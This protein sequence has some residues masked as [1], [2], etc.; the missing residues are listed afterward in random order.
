MPPRL[1]P[2]S[3]GCQVEVAERL[4]VS[5]SNDTSTNHSNARELL[6]TS[7]N[8]IIGSQ[9]TSVYSVRRNST[10]GSALRYDR[11]RIHNGLLAKEAQLI[12]TS[13]LSR[14]ITSQIGPKYS[15]LR[16]STLRVSVPAS[17]GTRKLCYCSEGQTSQT[18][19]KVPAAP[20]V[21]EKVLVSGEHGV[22]ETRLQRKEPLWKHGH[23]F[24]IFKYIEN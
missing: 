21:Q 4:S 16:T 7:T 2:D 22:I 3:M 15:V 11:G 13:D 10:G 1:V 24:D 14:P 17:S 19:D 20:S 23:G 6:E 12:L 9:R 8:T 5:C 18:S